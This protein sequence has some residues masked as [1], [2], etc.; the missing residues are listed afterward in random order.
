M[1]T[2]NVQCLSWQEDKLN[3]YVEVCSLMLG[4]AATASL[5]ED[6]LVDLLFIDYHGFLGLPP[7]RLET[8]LSLPKPTQPHMPLNF[9]FGQGEAGYSHSME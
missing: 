4:P 9:N 1:H 7:D 2:I 8:P 6:P 3:V 5:A